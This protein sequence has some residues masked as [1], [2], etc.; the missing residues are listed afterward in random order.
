MKKYIIILITFFL[1]I[2]STNALP[3]RFQ[4]TLVRCVDG[5][6]ARFMVEGVNQSTRFLAIDTPEYTTKKETYG[7]EASAFT[8]DKLMSAKIIELE[9]DPSS[10]QYDKY[11]RLL[12]WIYVDGVLLQDEII[13]KGLGEVAYLYGD[14]KYTSILEQSE[15]VAKNKQIGVWQTSNPDLTTTDYIELGMLIIF[16]ITLYYL[17]SKR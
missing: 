9:L 17:K 14:Y 11:D 13:K 7:K 16:S 15:I 5:D 8:C 1:F 3:N 2:S 4:T 6:T 10:N 12:A